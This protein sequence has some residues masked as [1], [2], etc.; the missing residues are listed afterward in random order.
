MKSVNL[1]ITELRIKGARIY[2][3]YAEVGRTVSKIMDLYS[4]VSIGCSFIQGLI[5]AV[6][7]DPPYQG[8]PNQWWVL[9]ERQS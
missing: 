2:G 7:P 9:P 3:S 8:I 1:K 5:E 4:D 6:S